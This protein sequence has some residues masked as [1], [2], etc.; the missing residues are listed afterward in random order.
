MH[1]MQLFEQNST[2]EPSSKGTPTP[3]DNMAIYP[4]H[5]V[6]SLPLNTL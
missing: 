4:I 6:I 1:A 2:I 3:L 5:P